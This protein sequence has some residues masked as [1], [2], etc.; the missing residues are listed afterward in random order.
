MAGS[1]LPE[2]HNL[3]NMPTSSQSLFFCFHNYFRHF[4]CVQTSTTPWV[5]LGRDCRTVRAITLICTIHHVKTPKTCKRQRVLG[6]RR[7]RWDVA[8]MRL[9]QQAFHPAFRCGHSEHFYTY[10]RKTLKNFCLWTLLDN[11]L[12][13]PV[14]L[15][16]TEPFRIHHISVWLHV[17]CH[18][19]S[20]VKSI[21]VAITED[22]Q[23]WTSTWPNLQ[24][25]C[26]WWKT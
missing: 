15:K 13:N 19:L 1:E 4:L 9:W 21:F 16:Q 5:R 3:T 26:Y 10:T 22:K 12:Y 14:C 6:E 20:H 23:K 2:T 11:T 17:P 7:E 18:W 24:A 8:T 25:I